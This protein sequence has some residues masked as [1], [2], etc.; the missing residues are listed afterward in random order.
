MTTS[1]GFSSKP[2]LTS[3]VWLSYIWILRCGACVL[4]VAVVR[5]AG[6]PDQEI[7]KGTVSTIAEQTEGAGPLSPC[8]LI[9]GSVVSL[10]GE[11]S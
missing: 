10:S 3:V 6:Q 9:I 8:V 4:Q 1:Q 5:A 2:S 7:W 11:P